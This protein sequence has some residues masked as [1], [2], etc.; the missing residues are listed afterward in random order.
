MGNRLHAD[1]SA[2]GWATEQQFAESPGGS[3]RARAKWFAGHQPAT[4]IGGWRGAM[5]V[6]IAITRRPCWYPR[7]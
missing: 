2:R 6:L 4:L 3:G 1:L 7:W 5:L